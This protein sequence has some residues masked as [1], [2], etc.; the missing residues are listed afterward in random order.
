[1]T[2][3]PVPGRSAVYRLDVPM[4]G[5][6]ETN[7][8]YVID[9]PEP[10]L[11]DTG[12]AD[13][14]GAIRDALDAL[15]IAPAELSYIVPTHA[16]LDH[17]G[18]AGHLA[19]VCE[20]AAVVCHP[21]AAPYLTDEARLDHLAASVERA[22]GMPDP[23]GDPRVIDPDRCLTL[24]DGD[25]LGVGDRALQAVDAPGHAP[26]QFCLF[27]PVGDILF[28]ADAAGMRLGDD[29]RPTTPP[30]DFDPD[31]AVET[32]GRLRAFDP[33]TVCY[34]HFGWGEPGNGASEL[35]TYAGILREFVNQVAAARDAGDDASS[36]ADAL[37]EEWGHWSLEV[38]V[39]GVLRY[40][41]T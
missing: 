37:R 26:H 24:E 17:A 25:T 16:H 19:A 14:T 10:T 22:I 35:G 38:D 3:E 15:D 6:R 9:A 29:H 4:F 7:S 40:L 30:P 5:M 21:E 12:P 34:A 2:H 36:V 8:P 20:N 31:R 39:A 28:S 32:I 33:D 23:Y 41:R 11:V 1:M 13:A 27:D 18:G